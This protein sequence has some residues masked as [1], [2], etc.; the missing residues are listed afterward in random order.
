MKMP[1]DI[2]LSPFY[3]DMAVDAPIVHL[4]KLIPSAAKVVEQD[5]MNAVSVNINLR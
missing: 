2:F 1:V 4:R 5:F 3:G